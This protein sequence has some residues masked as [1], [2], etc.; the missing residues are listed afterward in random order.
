MAAKADGIGLASSPDAIAIGLEAA[1][2]ARAPGVHASTPMV[3]ELAVRACGRLGLDHS[4]LTLVDLC[5]RVRDV[6]M[7][8]LPDSVVLATGKLAPA[9]WELVN[10]HPILGAE[11]LASTDGFERAVPVVRSHHERWDGE[12]YPD[13][14]RAEAI[15]LLARIIAGA[16]AFVAMASDRP[17][18]RGMGSD[19]ALDHLVHERGR[20]FDPRVVD[21]LVSVISGAPGDQPVRP[22]GPRASRRAAIGSEASDQRGLAASL[23]RCAVLPAFTPALERLLLACEDPSSERA[24]DDALAAIESDIG[25][26]VSVLRAAQ[27]ATRRP[28]T[29]VADAL[30]ALS[31]EQ[32]RAA[33][34]SLPQAA[35]PWRSPLEGLMHQLRVHAQ[36]VSRAAQRIAGEVEFRDTDDLVTVVLLH[37]VGKLVLAQE[38]D[39]RLRDAWSA[40]LTPERRVQAERQ[41]AG[42]DHASLGGLLIDRWGLPR[43]L[44]KAVSAHHSADGEHELVTLL[45]LADMVAHQAHGDPVDRTLMLKLAV[46]SGLSVA[47]LRDALFDLPHATGSQ[48]RRALASPLSARETLVLRGLAQGKLYKEIAADVGVSTSTVRTHLHNAYGKLEVVDRAQA[49]LRA[50]EMGWI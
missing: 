20:Q 34:A 38:Y 7:L 26:S 50:T 29:N 2:K 27:G 13:G 31:G 9:D 41:L 4:E 25:L 18:R 1:L 14:L 28:I 37:D 44:S 11:L 45:R 15:P 40:P 19:A 6:G 5:S 21:A 8:A 39:D 33:V 10:R 49:V 17:H 16:D 43:K 23:A 3:R 46:S 48:R 47:A 32:V 12:G 36:S 42:I 22:D 35:F 30:R 24:R